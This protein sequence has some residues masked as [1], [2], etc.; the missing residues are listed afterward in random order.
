MTDMDK[1]LL[2]QSIQTIRELKTRLAQAEQGHQEAVA[3]VGVSL[4]FPGGVTD[5]DS[6]WALLREGRSGV[7]E[8]EPERWSNRQFVDPDYAAAGKL[9]T[10]Y[11]GLLEHIYDFDAEFFGLS[12]LEAENLDPQQRLLL[13]QSWLALEDAGYDIGRLRGS[14]TGVVVGIGSQDYGMALLADPA[15]ANPY[16]A[17]GN[18]L[19]MAAGRLSYFFDFSGPSLSIDTACSSSLVAVHEACRRLQLGECG[20][21]LAAGVNAML[22]PHA[23]INFSRARMLSTERD[24]HTFDARAKGYVRGEGCAV[25]VLKR[26]ADAQ[27]DGDRI[28]A[29]IRGVAINHDGHS[30]GLTVPNGSAQRAVIR[31]ALRRAGVA[32]AEVDYAEAHGTGTR[33]GDPIEAHAIADVY[34]EAREAGRPLV[35]GAVKA[36]LGHLE[37]AAGLA[38]L[39]KAMLVVR[40][41]EA[42]PQPGFETLNPAIG[43]DTAKFKVV[44][45]PT[46]LRPADG[47][48]WLAG[49]SSFGFS[50]TNAHAIVAAAPLAA[51]E[52]EPAAEPPGGLHVLALSAKTPEALGR[53]VEEVAAY[54]AGKPAAEL[55]AI[56]QTSTCRRVALGERIAVTGRD[57][58]ELAARLRRALAERAPRRAPG[59]IVLYLSS[60]DLPAGTADPAALAALHRGWLAR[61]AGF[62]LFPDRVVLRGIAPAFVRAWLWQ[63]AEPTGLAYLDETAGD[64]LRGFSTS[65]TAAGEVIAAEAAAAELFEDA[66]VLALG[67]P[68]FALPASSSTRWLRLDDEAAL[69]TTL[70]ALFTAGIEIDW[71]PLDARRHRVV[72]DFP[73]RPFARRSFRSP[74]IDAALAGADAPRESESAIHP[75][76][77]DRLAQPDGRVSCRLRT[78]TAWL[79]F[80]DG[81][82][83]QGHRLLPA[84]LLLELMRAAAADARGAAVTL[85]DA[86]FRRPFDLDAAA[87]DY[88]VQVDAPGEGARVALWGRPADDAAAPWVEHASAAC[89]LAETTDAQDAPPAEVEA[90][91]RDWP[92]E[93][94]HELDVGALY[95]R[96]QA[97]DIVLGED[98]RCLAALRVR[99]A[100]SEAEVG[101]PR[102]AGHDATQRAALLIDACL[103]ASAAT[104]EADDGLFLLAGVGEVVL[105]PA[106]ALPE[107]LRVR[108]V[109]EACDEG[110]RFTITLA[111]AEGAPVGRL[112]EVLFRRVQG[113]QRAAPFHETGWEAVEW[114]ARAAAPMHAALPAPDA[115]D[116][117][118]ASATWAARFGLDSYDAYRGQ[119]EQACA[120]IVAD[121]LADLGHEG[122][123]ME[124]AAD[125]APAQQRLFAH[126]LAVRA[127]GDAVALAA[128]AARLD[129]VAAAFPQFH[130]ETEFLRR[131]A[132]ALPEVL[133]GRRNPLE[134]L[135]GGSAFDGS[136]AVYVDSPIARVLNGQ[137]AQW[138]ARLAAQRPLRI[139]EIGAGTGGTSRTVLDALRGLPVARYCYT[140]V[141]PLFLERARPRFGE[142]GFIDYR[143]LD[144]EQP[145]ADQG[146]TAGEFDLVIAA[147]VLHATRS[148]ADTLRQ[149]RELLAPGG[150]LLLRECTAQRLSADLSFGM[151]EGWWRFEDHALRADYAVLSV[152]QWERQLALAGFE[153]TLGLP[154]SEASAE[155]LIVAQASA[156]DRAEHWLVVHDGQGVGCVAQLAHERIAC[157]ELSWAEALEA[158]PARES[159]QHIVCFADAG[160]RDNADPVAAATAQYEAMIALCR[161]WLGPEAAP[162]ARLWCVTRQA[163]RAVDAD[164]VDGLGQSVAAGVLKCAA[165]EFPGRVA[166]L[167]DLEAEPADFA[168]LIAHWREPGELRCFALR[169]GR[170]HVPRLRPLDAG[171][172]G[173]SSLAG[174]AAFDGTVLITGGFGGIGLAL[175]DTLAARVETLVLVGRQ[176]GGPERE[177]QLAALRERGA[178]VIALAA[179]LADDAQVAALFA[180]LVAEGVAV[181]HLIHAA[182]VGGSLALAASGRGELRE[183]V[184][185]K[186]AG[187]WHLHRHAG[188]SLKSFTVLSTMLALWGAREKAHYTLAN[189]FAERVVEWR[190]ARGL[191]ASIVHLGPVDGGMLDAAGKAAAAR[192]GVRSFTLRELAGWLA[193]PLPRPGIALLDIDW[194]RF[195]PIYRHG[196][197]DALFAELGTPADGGAAGAKAADGAAA[198]RRAYAAAGY[199]ESM[200]DELLHALLSEVLGLSGSFAAYAGTG[201]HDLGMD[202][203]LTLSFAEKLGARV[204]LPVSSVDVFDNANPARL[205]GWLAARLKALYAAAPAAAGS[206]GNAGATG[207]T[208]AFSAAG[209]T[210]PDATDAPP[211]AGPLAATV[212][213]TASDAA[214]DAVTDEI[215][216]EL[217][218]MQALLEDR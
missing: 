111:D 189:H 161:R 95:A 20:L 154:P 160:E 50:G 162:G 99:G 61:C 124:A 4:R 90:E 165:L 60:A 41:G 15:H 159:Y 176:V 29:V 59:R 42:P 16:V 215:E 208:S 101:P 23:G 132:A 211:P 26:L 197:L 45:Q 34:G 121:T 119:I 51:E 57:S 192:V 97:G 109:R 185:A 62:G 33:L 11:A 133:R 157:R 73:R 106:V 196:W 86:R 87:C 91:G 66:E 173:A 212:S 82:R 47:R 150:Y 92:A 5:L 8:V 126:L 151:T 58:A 127:R 143:L 134:V 100:R 13:E 93:G 138:A 21:A 123:D 25:L 69:R 113:A 120:G 77:R 182:G 156:V 40:H 37:A 149:V 181:S 166:G 202:S 204:G 163:E 194:A 183:V 175:A 168:A 147:N 184:D 201:F 48:P 79:D 216:R 55:A 144:I 3:V 136:E 110:Y 195:R 85:S 178:R 170:P 43:W 217:Q 39:I 137:L 128:G 36:N 190:R 117:L 198:F 67:A 140:D 158:D 187:T 102:G 17:S 72:R 104:R 172:L 205:R 171:A 214:G 186:L 84:S 98:F 107:R 76:V 65:E 139:V 12:A 83:V 193:A 70:A 80:I 32:P 145:I 115:L 169:G 167:V 7:I 35:I 131:C 56:A 188:P 78:A 164:R 49:V 125:V 28:H 210:H 18:S 10:P 71:T 89:R 38:G 64:A 141:S 88:L 30:S 81:H 108:L 179:D 54:L 207:A 142:E 53:H 116:G 1:D 68:P 14:D 152:A 177:A 105:P 129:G 213:P 199:R 191:P 96:H 75:L 31:A 24:C 112:R 6:Y 22:T 27:A 148:I 206:T 19:S 94:W 200:L 218:T 174:A 122:A 74:R 44:R 130:G 209:A 180:R 9:V 46:P 114:P 155:A 203:L 135:F 52:G 146:F 2:L 63:H 103:Q 153:H 118:E